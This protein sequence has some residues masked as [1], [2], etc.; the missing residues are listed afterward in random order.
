MVHPNTD[1]DEWREA[2]RK[3]FV[4][5]FALIAVLAFA[6]PQAFA[7]GRQQARAMSDQMKDLAG[8]TVGIPVID[9]QGNQV[10]QVVA[11]TARDNEA[12]YFLVALNGR[13]G[14]LTPIPFTAARF[15]PQTKVL[16]LLDVEDP[17]LAQA[18]AARRDP[19][20]KPDDPDLERRFRGYYGEEPGEQEE[21]GNG[22][23]SEEGMG[24]QD[25]SGVNI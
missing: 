2:M 12:W 22:I 14:E 18:P 15:D 16:V 3:A 13:Q 24:S 9:L 17:E 23:N 10:G 8:A 4:G 21:S 7:D 1:H 19:L 20:Q 6:P 11:L 25:R 5:A